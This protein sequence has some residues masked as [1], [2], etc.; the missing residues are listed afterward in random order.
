MLFI[1]STS[2]M[3]TYAANRVL[4]VD[5][6]GPDGEVTLD[7]NRATNLPCAYTAFATCPLPSAE[8]RLPVAIEAGEQRHQ[9]RRADRRRPGSARRSEGLAPRPSRVSGCP[10]VG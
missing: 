10:N 7:F 4:L 3:T 8:N 1:D 2:G 9:P 5:V 6:P